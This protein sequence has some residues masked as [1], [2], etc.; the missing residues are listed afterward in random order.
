[1]SKIN[2]VCQETITFAMCYAISKRV[3]WRQQKRKGNHGMAVLEKAEK[4]RSSEIRCPGKKWC[5]IPARDQFQMQPMIWPG[6]ILCF[7]W[8]VC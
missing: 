1:M 6:L 4:R 3:Y 8:Q 7:T 5:R 2:K